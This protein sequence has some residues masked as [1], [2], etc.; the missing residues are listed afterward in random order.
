MAVKTDIKSVRTGEQ[1]IVITRV[2]NAPRELVWKAWTEAESLAQWWGPKGFE[3][4]VSKLDFRPNGIFHYNM[5][6]P[7]GNKIWGK[8]VYREMNAPEKMVF[9]NSFSDEKGGITSNPYLANWPLEVLNT[10]TL[11]EQDGKTTLTLRGGPINANELERKN[12]MDHQSDMQQGFN[13]TFEK[14]DDYLERELRD[15]SLINPPEDEAY[16][17]RIFDAP[18][19]LVWKLWSEPES[20][21]KWWGPKDFT[22]PFCKIDFRI[23]GQYHFCMRSPEGKDYWST[24]IYSEIVKPERIACTDSFADEQGNVV[25]ASY[26]GMTGDFPLELQ[27]I[28]NFED[29]EGRTRF[30]LRH[31][32][33]PAGQMIDLT[34]QGWNESLDK[35]AEVLKNA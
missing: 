20:I 5:Q 30:S 15:Y 29:Y 27:V 16:I 26:Y 23:G 7:D 9:V 19:E 35:F 1:E 12:F 31:I 8:F 14:L 28:L 18:R 33:I 24:G 3:I 32:G 13:G 11:L 22:A 34:T 2:F 25:P 17:T 10:L 21:K 4:E 6:F